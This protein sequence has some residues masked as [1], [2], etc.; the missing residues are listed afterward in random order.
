M[1]ELKT[2]RVSVV[3]DGTKHNIIVNESGALTGVLQHLSTKSQKNVISIVDQENFDITD[4]AHLKDNGVYKGE[5]GIGGSGGG[6][7]GP[8]S[9]TVTGGDDGDDGRGDG[10]QA[11]IPL[12][13]KKAQIGLIQDEHLL[14]L[15]EYKGALHDLAALST[16][17]FR[18][19]VYKLRSK[20][21]T[22]T[23]ND[24]YALYKL[25]IDGPVPG[26]YR[27]AVEE[28]WF[29]GTEQT[30]ICKSSVDYKELEYEYTNLQM[31]QSPFVVTPTALYRL[32]NNR[33]LLVL[34]K[35][36]LSLEN[37][38]PKLAVPDEILIDVL[39]SACIGLF[40]Y[41]V[42][43]FCFGD[44][45]PGN[46]VCNKHKVVLID[47]GGITPFGQNL[48]EF[49]YLNDS[50][51]ASE[52][53]DIYGLCLTIW[54]LFF[55][56][57]MAE[58][59]L[60]ILPSSKYSFLQKTYPICRNARNV[61]DIIEAVVS[62]ITTDFPTYLVCLTPYLNVIVSDV[63]LPLKRFCAGHLPLPVDLIDL[64]FGYVYVFQ[65]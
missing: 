38:F 19:V 54:W 64:L 48:K 8:T 17:Q 58:K 50:Q 18:Q 39:L 4:L 61:V 49:T 28:G 34:P 55:K 46:L 41:H 42:Q 3:V 60:R 33:G 2:K 36:G 15:E 56:T 31:V 26:H 45:K 25:I 63:F 5:I 13:A 30:V 10:K 53:H 65:G 44:I 23:G 16:E 35:L 21:R 24:L 37:L 9:T 47:G 62:A 14:L 11:L 6:L 1:S 51:Y 40:S 57:K 43:G 20:R 59:N 27:H 7:Q 32:S 52:A 29:Y 12:L 22:L